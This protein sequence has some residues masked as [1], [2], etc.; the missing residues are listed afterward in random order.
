MRQQQQHPAC[1]RAW[2]L[3]R[4]V[5]P[6]ERTTYARPLCP[7]SITPNMTQG[8]NQVVSS[9]VLVQPYNNGTVVLTLNRPSALNALNLESIK[10]LGAAVQHFIE[11]PH[12][13]V[14][15]LEGQGGRAFCAGGDIRLLA[16]AAKGGDERYPH[17][18]FSLEYK[19]DC[20]IHELRKPCVA[21]LDGITMGGGVG[22]SVGAPFRIATEA[23][24]FAMPET[25]IGFFPDVGGGYFLSRLG[26]HVGVYL[27]LTG[28]RLKAADALLIG[29][30][31]HYVPKSKVS[32]LKECLQAT[33]WSTSSVES[34]LD[35]FATQPDGVAELSSH[36]PAIERCFS[37]PTV[38][39]ILKKLEEE[40]TEWARSVQA[41]IAKKSPTS[42]KVTLKAVQLGKR[43]NIR[44]AFASDLRVAMSFMKTKDFV[45]GVR[46][47][48]IDKDNKPRWH[49]TALSAV[50]A[51]Y[52]D[53]F[54]AS[55]SDPQLELWSS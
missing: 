49:P 33:D 28:A 29:L 10:E 18:F 24:L 39:H 3:Q 30:V 23:F 52:V 38:E 9:A 40:N 34:V 7:F 12:K 27:A 25:G 35:R 16:E 46:A 48:I 47:V 54:F 36:L 11:N 6:A 5:I 51:T 14:L 44:E 8:I 31:T 1:R 20:Q 55:F 4:H 42:L 19:L 37:Q 45:E 13:K 22:L 53:A 2:A 21:L 17:Q 43:Q 26:R 15:V 41:T 50:S 32:Q